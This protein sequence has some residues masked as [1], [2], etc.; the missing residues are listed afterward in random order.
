MFFLTASL[1]VYSLV[2]LILEVSGRKKE[3]KAIV[4]I[5]SFLLII[6]SFV[7]IIYFAAPDLFG[8]GSLKI[9]ILLL[10]FFLVIPVIVLTKI[11]RWLQFVPAIIIM[12]YL[13]GIFNVRKASILNL[14]KQAE[15]FELVESRMKENSIYFQIHSIKNWNNEHFPLFT[16]SDKTLINVRNPQCRGHFPIVWNWEEMPSAMMG[17]Y[18]SV[19]MNNMWF[20]NPDKSNRFIKI[21][22]IVVFG[23]WEFMKNDDFAELRERVFEF[24][25]L[26]T[27]TQDGLVG[28]LKF[29]MSDRFDSIFN[30]NLANTSLKDYYN[31][32]A[33]EYRTSFE[34]AV[35]LATA[36]DFRI[37]KNE[38]ISVNYYLKRIYTSIEWLNQVKEK[39]HENGISL[40]QMVMIDAKYMYDVYLSENRVQENLSVDYYIKEILKDKDWREQIVGKAEEKGVSFSE[41]VL[42]DA[43]Y[44]FELVTKENHK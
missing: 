33:L 13:I 20:S 25:S 4:K 40:E 37:Y 17:K 6:S 28:L 36:E 10:F 19:D 15:D 26:D 41:M 22:Y 9:R 23:Y 35:F 27:L 12:W 34:N 38:P 8:T 29:N 3:E 1:F 18:S 44:M 30:E 24:Y 11:P 21:D 32:K 31:V 42:V 2:V 43:K 14:S 7:F 5:K 16:G 39:A